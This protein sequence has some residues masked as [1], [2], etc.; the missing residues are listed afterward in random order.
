MGKDTKGTVNASPSAV[1]Q[2]APDA[3]H[4]KPAKDTKGITVKKAD[5][6]SEWYTQVIQKADLADYSAVSGCIVYKPGSYAIWEKIQQ[7]VDARL[8]AMGVQNAA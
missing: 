5:D 3:H 8:K 1:H 7:I 2:P 6:F 4:R